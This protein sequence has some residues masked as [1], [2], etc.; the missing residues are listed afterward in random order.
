MKHIRTANKKTRACDNA[1]PDELEIN[2]QQYTNSQDITIKLKDYL[3]SICEYI[4]TNDIITSSPDLTKLETDISSKIQLDTYFR[5]P[6]RIVNQVSEFINGLN[7]AKATGLDGIG[8]RILKLASAVLTPSISALINKSIETATFPN[9]LKWPNC[10]LFIKVA[11]NLIQPIT[12]RFLF[13]Q[14]FQ[15]FSKNT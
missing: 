12:D 3:A 9:Q 10:T 5:I 13:F 1:L 11:R 15:K 2:G 6:K 14:R 7:P 4:N 8:P